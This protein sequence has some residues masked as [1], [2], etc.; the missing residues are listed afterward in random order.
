MNAK[1]RVREFIRTEIML[2]EASSELTD[3]TPILKDVIDSLG[4]MQLVSFLEEEFGVEI[5]DVDIT[6]ENFTSVEM[7]DRFL[8]V[9][10]AEQPQRA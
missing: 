1:D 3:E 5:E 4:L 2:E 6:S 10:L 9:K 8:Q 7:I